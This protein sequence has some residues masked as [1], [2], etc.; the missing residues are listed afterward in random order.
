MVFFMLREGI[1]A[2]AF[3]EGVRRFWREQRFRIASW[4]D[5]KS[6]FEY[7]SGR[8]LAA[9]FDQWLSRAGAPELR[10]ADARAVSTINGWRLNVTLTQGAPGYALSVP[11]AIRTA[12][13]EITRRVEIGGERDTVAL[14]MAQQPL[15]V[16]LDPDFR[17]FRRL[18]ASEAP[19]ILREGMLAGS[20]MMFSLSDHPA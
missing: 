2:A 15:A 18:A 17:V 11:L 8:D 1:G 14:D 9:F 16:V 7:A 13:G 20:P 5:L 4:N 12:G 19:P 6:A 3:D 10:I